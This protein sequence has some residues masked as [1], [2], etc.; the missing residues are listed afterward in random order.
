ML[1]PGPFMLWEV[2]ITWWRWLLFEQAP[3]SVSSCPGL[4]VGHSAGVVVLALI[5]IGLKDLAH[6]ETMSSW[7]EFLVG[8]ALLVVG[9]QQFAP[10][11]GLNCTPMN[12]VMTV[13]QSIAISICMCAVP[14]T[15]VATCMPPLGWVC[16]TDWPGPVTSWR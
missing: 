1:Q 7:A 9:A 15:T 3:G 10:H 13:P 6:V 4:G 5:A 16:C 14:A 11:S 8:V 2:P 12:T